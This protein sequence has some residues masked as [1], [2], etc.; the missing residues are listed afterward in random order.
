MK[1]VLHNELTFTFHPEGKD[2]FN[3]G[4]QRPFI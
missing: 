2:N 1:Q 4:R 3:R